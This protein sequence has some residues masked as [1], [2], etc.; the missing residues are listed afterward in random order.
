MAPKALKA[1]TGSHSVEALTLNNECHMPIDTPH[2]SSWQR[3]SL[4][5]WDMEHFSLSL[6]AQRKRVLSIS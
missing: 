6:F 4:H 1:V 5:L 3:A 2:G